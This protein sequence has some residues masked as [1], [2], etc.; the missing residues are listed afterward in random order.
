MNNPKPH[1]H[2]AAQL[3]VLISLDAN[4][5]ATCKVL[6]SDIALSY[7]GKCVDGLA[8]G[9]GIARGTDRYEGEFNRGMKHG[10]GKYVWAN[11]ASYI[12][13]YKDDRKHGTGKFD[14]GDGDLFEGNFA[15][16]KWEGYGVYNWRDGRKYTGGHTEGVREG[17]GRMTVPRVSVKDFDT[18]ANGKYIGN[19]YVYEGFFE[20]GKYRFPCSSVQSCAAEVEKRNAQAG[21][22]AI[23]N[24]ARLVSRL[25]G[26][27]SSSNG[28]PVPRATGGGG[29]GDVRILGDSTGANGKKREV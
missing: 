6:D 8:Q 1:L 4:A 5:Q 10:S 13:Q 29:T 15:D 20:S 24:A 2:I 23:A 12:G 7:E 18:N 19:T 9:Q 26:G 17:F 21:L 11:G 27:Y 14:F 16:G 28:S 3:F 22:E 25:L